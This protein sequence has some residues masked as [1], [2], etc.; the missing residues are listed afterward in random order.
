M[1]VEGLETFSLDALRR[2]LERGEFDEALELER[3]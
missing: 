1:K 3:E 2:E